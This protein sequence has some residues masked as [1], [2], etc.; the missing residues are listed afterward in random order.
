MT[1]N[2]YTVVKFHFLQITTSSI[3]NVMVISGIAV[4]LLWLILSKQWILNRVT[5]PVLFAC[6]ALLLIRIILPAEYQF[7][8]TVGVKYILPD[9]KH[10]FDKRIV[11]LF[12]Y[13]LCIYHV[14]YLVWLFGSLVLGVRALRGWSALKR[15]VKAG[16]DVKDREIQ[17]AFAL[18]LEQHKIKKPIRLIQSEE[19]ENPM[20]FGIRT[21]CI[22]L[23]EIKLSVKEWAYILEHEV[24]HYCHGDLYVKYLLTLLTVLYWWN[25]FVHILSD[26]VSKVLELR[27]D[28]TVIA[29]KSE[30]E[31][32][33]YGNCLLQLSKQ[34]IIRKKK[35][36][37][38]AISFI[39]YKSFSLSQ[40]FFFVTERSDEKKGRLRANLVVLPMLICTLLSIC[41]IYQPHYRSPEKIKGTIVLT[42]ENAYMIKN[43]ENGYDVYYEGEY[44]GSTQSGNL[45]VELP[46]YDSEEDVP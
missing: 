39:G 42:P 31:R 38:L 3:I 45:G 40:R 13:S 32:L 25:P 26:Q 1:L 35:A 5:F 19:V 41:F 24:A 36:E 9:I 18:V 30:E 2:P 20:I 15:C 16:T 44:F 37:S 14:L 23:P 7:T 4:L 10:F 11:T 22:F 34:S 6:L 27:T 12:G 43:A 33:E 29:S 8:N 28:Q 17:E 21:P 46:I